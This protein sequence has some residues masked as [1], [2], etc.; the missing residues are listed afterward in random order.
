MQFEYASI[1]ALLAVSLACT[2]SSV[3]ALPRPDQVDNPW[4]NPKYIVPDPVVLSG[5]AA[6]NTQA[7][8]V[9][10]WKHSVHTPPFVGESYIHDMKELEREKSAT[11][12]P[13]LN[14]GRYEVRM[15]HNSN[16]RRA[17]SVPVKIRHVEEK[18][19]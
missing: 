2:F 11:F 13:N 10:K 7:I 14:A 4:D 3:T 5:I 12:I 16:I 9:G 18:P 15:P 17:N 6:D 8:L 1:I 19:T